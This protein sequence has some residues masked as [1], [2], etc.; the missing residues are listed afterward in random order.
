MVIA[1]D[2]LARYIDASEAVALKA[3]ALFAKHAELFK[4]HTAALV[5]HAYPLEARLSPHPL[6]DARGDIETVQL[7]GSVLEGQIDA[8]DLKILAD[9]S[10][11]RKLR[12]ELQSTSGA[13]P[14]ES[15]KTLCSFASD[16]LGGRGT[17]SQVEFIRA[18]GDA[19]KDIAWLLPFL[20]S[21]EAPRDLQILM[22]S[23]GIA[24]RL[25][26]YG[27]R[28]LARA[29]V[30]HPLQSALLGAMVVRARRQTCT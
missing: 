6:E 15:L 26:V 24:G 12:R 4:A 1:I 20:A 2:D 29:T 8:R 17:D 7:L 22:F 16:K 13:E 23:F 28:L 10:T 9:D 3:V 27:G 19:T 5:G 30:I 11:F 14:S 25:L 21:L 18:A